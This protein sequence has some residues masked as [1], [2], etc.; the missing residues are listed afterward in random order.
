M[1]VTPDTVTSAKL[2]ANET[3]TGADG[4]KLTG[5][6][7]TKTSS[8][9]TASGA[10]VTAPAGYYASSASKSV[11]SG[12]AK[13]PATTVTANPTI[14]VNSSTG[15]ITATTSAT[16][17]VTP[18]VT[19][20]Y[21]SSGTAGTITVSGSKTSQLSTQAATTITPTTSSQTAV[22]AGKYTTGAV[23]VGAIPSQYIVP[24][25]TVS[26]TSNGTTDVTSYASASVAVEPTLQEKTVT[27]TTSTQVVT[28]DSGY[29]GLS[30]VTVNAASGG[31]NM[32]TKTVTPAEYTQSVT[33]DTYTEYTLF[34]KD[35]A[36]ALGNRS[37]FTF[38]GNALWP[39]SAMGTS[40]Y[41]PFKLGGQIYYTYD[42]QS[43]V[44]KIDETVTYYTEG[45]T[46]QSITYTKTGDATSPTAFTLYRSYPTTQWAF[47]IAFG[48]TKAISALITDAIVVIEYVVPST[49]ATIATGDADQTERRNI[50]TTNLQI[51]DTCSLNGYLNGQSSDLQFI[52]FT[53]DG[54]THTF[55]FHNAT[56]QVTPTQL[57]ASP[58]QGSGVYSHIVL[59][60]YAPAAVL[61]DGLSEVTVNP[62]PSQYVVPTGTISIAENGTSIDV[63]Q[64]ALADVSVPVV[65]SLVDK[66]VDSPSEDLPTYV[67]K[68]TDTSKKIKSSAGA[69]ARTAGTSTG[70]MRP[71]DY[72]ATLTDG[73]Q[74]R[75]VGKLEVFDSNSITIETHNIDTVITIS[76]SP[77]DLY[78]E[79]GE[80][81]YCNRAQIERYS[82]N[83]VTY[84]SVSY[85]KDGTY[86]WRYFI[87]VFEPVAAY[88]GLNVVAVN[89]PNYPDSV[90]KGLIQRNITSTFVIPSG[91]TRIGDYA[92]R[93]CTGIRISSIPDTV[94]DIGSYAFYGVNG[95]TTMSLPSS[96]TYIGPYAFYSCQ[97]MTSINWP[98]GVHT[99]YQAVFQNCFA[100][101]TM[102]LPS[103]VTVIS[104]DAFN[105][106][107]SLEEITLPDTV[108]SFGT[109]VFRYASSL[110]DVE[111]EGAITT[112]GAYTFN[113]NSS[114][115]MGLKS[116]SFP[117][118]TTAGSSIGNIFGSSTAANACQQLE[119]VD[120]GSA[121][122]LGDNLFANCYV[123]QTLVLR[124]TDAVCEVVYTSAFTNTPFTG[125]NSLT[126][127]VYVPSA[128][129]SSYQTATNWSTYY[130][131]G[132]VTF[133]AIE[134]SPYEIT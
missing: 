53:W 119:F 5:S 30:Q 90:V 24:S 55:S 115:P 56:V 106:C 69:A 71:Y 99:V 104:S 38:T 111:C 80:N 122:A 63:S 86:G 67:T 105:G 23:T 51:G 102:S 73:E 40:Y 20:G 1:D 48:A 126:A 33:P 37:S 52:S 28:P 8:D 16:K 100:L 11:S 41:T 107:H 82:S 19:A 109:S 87:R 65:A 44:L 72:Y 85:S 97:N 15:L 57:I 129:I 58:L 47:T 42:G 70:F 116:A 54:E 35:T 127:T 101:E 6:I 117:N 12:S 98:T 84:I 94:T 36:I 121:H 123:L 50:D 66:T 95:I 118:L 83:G 4:V 93:G 25:G 18:T 128:L 2:L 96:L 39:S 103:G 13:T 91:T 59:F 7:A 130:N 113:G 89:P 125:Y 133:V 134:G 124:R 34:A 61:Y 88:D 62:I 10:T 32:Q 132:T 68:D 31:G 17:S 27:P 3:A 45:N 46:N 64:Y 60:K 120:F 131:N 75:F 49:L 74:Y 78:Y 79:T 92:F 81:L 21:V 76:S 110:T 14:S 77:T 22:A 114:Y 43:A 108:T 29:D 112:I 9:M 26:I